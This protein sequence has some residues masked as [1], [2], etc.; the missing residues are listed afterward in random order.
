MDKNEVMDK[1]A[2]AINQIQETSGR[3]VAEISPNT[4]P[5]TD[6]AGFDSLNGIEATVI[7]SDSLGVNLPDSVFTPKEGNQNLSVSEIADS[8][9]NTIDME[10]SD[11]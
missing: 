5:F 4:R 7:L 10:A 2:D 3:T 6:V 8:L 9:C 11:R 1:V